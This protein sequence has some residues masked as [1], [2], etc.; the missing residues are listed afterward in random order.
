[1]VPKSHFDGPEN[2]QLGDTPGGEPGDD[3]EIAGDPFFQRYNFPHT[4]EVAEEEG[5]SSS[6]ESSSDTEG[7]LSPTHMKGRPPGLS[8]SLPSPRSPVPSAISQGN[9]T[10]TMQDIN[11]VVVGA[12]G[13]GKSTF[14][15]R[16]L[17]LQ[18]A[19]SAI[20][21]RKMAVD[22]YAYVVR[23]LEL[24]C[25]DIEIGEGN[26]VNW[27][28]M[29][30]DIAMPRIDGV[31]T[32][33]DVTS[34]ASLAQVPEILNA[35]SKAS[36][37]F[38]L[39]AC[40]CDQH[41][42]HREVDPAVIEQ[43]AKTSFGEINTFQTSE[44][45]P[46]TQKRCLS[47]I[48][49]TII[50]AR[51][52]QLQAS[53]TRR[54]ANSSAVRRVSPRESWTRRHERA[55]SE[56]S[57]S[58][59]KARTPGPY[60]KDTDSKFSGNAKSHKYAPSDTTGHTFLDLEESPGYESFDT[61]PQESDQEQSVVSELPSDEKGYTFDQLVDRLLAQP[62]SK[63][64]TKFVAIFLALYRR[65]AT[66]GQLLEAIIKRFDALKRDKNPQI[67]RTIEQLRHLAILQQ[68]I[69][70]Y[71]GDFAYP[72]T[73]RAMRKF[74]SGLSSNR[75]FS[76]AAREM[77]QD[78]EIVTEDDDTDWACCDKNREPSDIVP[79]F[80]NVLDEDSESDE[81]T[82]AI[83][84][85]SM[86]T[87]SQTVSRSTTTTTTNTSRSMNSGTES[88]SSSSHTMLNSLEQAQKQA[89]KLVPN[90]TK[91]LSKVQWHLIMIASEED[92]AR[93]LTRID[94]IM[95]SSVRPRDL[96]RHG[97]MNA[98]EKKKCKSL[99]NVNRMID[100][101]NHLAYLVTNY[102]LLRDKPKHRALM[103]EKFMKIARKLREMNNYNS[104]GAVLAGIKGSAVH[105]LV[106]TRELIPQ[107]T[108]KD[109]MKLEI[110]MGTQKSYFAYRLAWENSSTE[111]IPYIPL[112]L[113]DLFSA[114][115]GNSTFVGD[116]K[117]LSAI[118]PHPGAPVF[119]S[120]IASRDSKEAP[121]G[122]VVG[123]ERI[124]W[125]KFEIMGEVIVGVQRAQGTPYPVL[126][127]N[128]D[129]RA[130]ILDLKFVKSDDELY[131]RSVQ[132]EAAGAGDRRRFN[133]F[134]PRNFNSIFSINYS[135]SLM[136]STPNDF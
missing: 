122:G 48:L 5:S 62:L 55:S 100:H 85:M 107:A 102:V 6:P 56:F 81:F 46:E 2:E 23:L 80:H 24:A 4:E 11:I 74:V 104:L 35:L 30:D 20:S 57:G 59:L 94:W 113:G 126:P 116:K 91:P 25:N 37:P 44:S 121:P 67:I 70:Y 61:E 90:P 134:Q 12:Q 124:N 34:Q 98:E 13:A 77:L 82:K 36:L 53:T 60:E 50:S 14:T 76:V 16:A 109:F 99:E 10:A 106:A 41:P 117:S 39:V 112:L 65:F 135:Q 115:K 52:V 111:R 95:F 84:S 120:A 129:V 72:T 47:V 83:G 89:R 114:S 133:W 132:L 64:D 93:E 29:I 40:K 69:S 7:P 131:D 130:L 96:V 108:V 79:T 110:L 103:L 136:Q 51:R 49:R 15:R 127:K 68:W 71:P 1:M 21:S 63:N 32:I 42:V 33:Y 92:I 123:K 66:P 87:D 105:R 3:E 125:R 28:E 97:S 58:R 128:D 88:S 43:K 86:G 73:R 9:D 54:R 26:C 31:V 38:L 27:P 118:S 119:Q 101:F 18:N 22:G 45:A 17:N 19:T 8:D 75:I 78:L